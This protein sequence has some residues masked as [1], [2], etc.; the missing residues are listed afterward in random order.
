MSVPPFYLNVLLLNKAE[1]VS[2][3]VAE[4][5]GMGMLG[6]AAG[7][8]ANRVVSDEKV[9]NSVGDVLV[10][11]LSAAIETLGIGCAMEKR[12]QHGCLVCFKVTISTIDKL[13]LILKSKGAEFAASFSRLLVA[14]GELG[15]E[16]L[17]LPKIDDAIASKVS[18]GM[19]ERMA[20]LVPQ[21]MREQ[22]LEVEVTTCSME[23][24]A[25]IFFD[26]V[27]RQKGL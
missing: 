7:S 9:L 4:K 15:I 25:E 2:S 8:L 10:E 11:K 3:K 27:E 18:E 22:G 21:R 23:E 1:V 26:L 17:A 24:Q 12:M 14:L 20:E 19:K 13:E 6:K 16:E 5:V